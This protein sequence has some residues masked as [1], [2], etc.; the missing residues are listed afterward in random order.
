MVCI[1][2]INVKGFIMRIITLLVSLCLSF[3]I[4]WAQPA[5]SD[6]SEQAPPFECDNNFG[7]CGTPEMSGGGGGG[8]GGG[9]ILIAN[10]DLGDTYQHADDFDDDGIEDPQDNCPRVRNIDQIDQDGDGLGDLCD[11]CLSVNNP[12]QFDKD[13]NGEGDVCDIDLDGDLVQ[14]PLD[15]CP[16]IANPFVDGLQPDLD[17]DGLGDACDDDIDGDGIP[18]LQDACPMK[19]DQD[20]NSND[21]GACFPDLDSDQIFDHE[22]NCI[23]F[24]NRDQ[25]DTDLDSIGDGCDED[26]DDD[27]ILDLKDNCPAVANPDQVDWDRDNKGD[28]CDEHACFVVFGDT[29]NCLDPEAY[30]QVYTPSLLVQTGEDIRL[31]LFANREN[32]ELDFSWRI[33]QAP[34]GASMA[35]ENATGVVSKSTPF[36]YNYAEG[37]EPVFM[38]EEPG[39][40]EIEVSIITRGADLQTSELNAK[41]VFKARIVAQGASISTSVG[42]EQSNQ[43]AFYILSLLLAMIT[44]VR[45][46]LA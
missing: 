2:I 9:S 39:E 16:E 40:Y 8:G 34:K 32:Q 43:S 29:A 36:E 21:V 20:F 38:A 24:Y 15:N 1:I 17:K 37:E 5:Q 45:R 26:D 30:L 11:N 6:G 23:A 14:N 19:A 12:L 4:A 44:V 41:S 3:N 13:G 25:L 7:A 35:I 28:L 27:G 42:C 31:R 18:S 46:R 10:T 22:D 33:V